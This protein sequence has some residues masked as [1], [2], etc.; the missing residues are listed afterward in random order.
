[1]PKNTNKEYILGGLE[2]LSLNDYKVTDTIK[3][4][5]VYD[6]ELEIFESQYKV[7]EGISYNSYAI[8]DD[9]IAI[10]D[11]VDKRA[12]YP[13]LMNL[14][15]TLD[16]KEP[17]FLVIL[18]VEPDHSA[19]IRNIAYKYPN[20]K[21]VG[22]AKTFQMISQF[23]DID[24]TDRTIVVKEGDT[25]E[26]G[27]HVLHFVMAPMVHW[28]EVMVAYESTEKVLFS[29]DAFGR[30]G[31]PDEKLTWDDEARRYFINIVGKYGVQVQ[32]LLKKAAA[33]DIKTICPLHGPVLKENLEH[34]ISKYNTWSSYEPEETGVLVAVASIHGST[35]NVAY[36]M[37]LMLEKSGVK[38]VELFDVTRE[39]IAQGVALAFKYD[40][41]IL[42]ASSYDG[43]VFMP[44]EDYLHHLVAKNFQNRKIGLVQ[45]GTWAPSA[46]KKMQSILEKQKNITYYDTIVTIK[47]TLDDSSKKAVEE[48]V[49]EV[50]C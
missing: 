46:A 10:M 21:L 7:K 26:L 39:D 23:H 38:N 8:M 36:E 31:Y 27:E 6:E 22:N 12:T 16:G 17:D 18:H 20:M 34:Y 45:N 49:K 3:H 15:K 40:R 4:L 19:N 35:Y 43:G 25:L 42:A 37:K 13:W 32:T 14:D 50:S 41:I 5:G 24:L 2:M 48:L 44:M 28:P 47:S 33:L 11:T 1:M 30:F 29:A 9:K